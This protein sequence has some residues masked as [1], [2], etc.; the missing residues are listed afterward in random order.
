MS[1]S[2]SQQG[3]CS[4]GLLNL[5][6]VNTSFVHHPEMQLPEGLHLNSLTA[7]SLGRR[8]TIVPV[9][10]L[11]RTKQARSAVLNTSFPR[12]SART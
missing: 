1:G 3:C 7:T 6:L 9:E 12:T 5:H 8:S 2:H 4:A 10:L 11:R